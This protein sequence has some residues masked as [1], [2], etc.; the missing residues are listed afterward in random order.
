VHLAG[1]ADL[2]PLGRGFAGRI[3]FE[4]HGLILDVADDDTELHTPFPSDH[5]GSLAGVPLIVEQ[6]VIGVLLVSSPKPGLFGA[7]DLALLERVGERAALAIGHAQLR[8]RERAVAEALQHS[9]LPDRLPELPEVRIAARYLS[10]AAG[11]DVGGDFYDAVRLD[12]G[13]LSLTIGDVAGKGLQ[14]ASI[15]G[16][17]R[18]AVRAYAVENDG[19]ETV[20]TLV[21]RL[22]Y[23]EE[24]MATAQNLVLEPATGVLRYANAGHP[25]G[26]RISAQGECT[27]LD[28]AL[29]PPLG[30]S[31]D[32]RSSAT[33]Q[34]EAG[35]RLLLFTDG[36][37][38]R[39][40]ELLDTGLEQVC[41]VAGEGTQEDLA[42]LS[43]A[44]LAA[45]S[46]DEGF[47]DDVALLA[48]EWVGA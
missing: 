11:V 36:L 1:A 25:P 48:V 14:A 21:D 41:K 23:G 42:T 3:A 32:K 15:M 37:V 44:V 17:L 38:E 26:L 40:D 22:A 43:D 35:D 9:L 19:P 34:L 30:T 20:L 24:A 45:M 18:S 16:R 10:R 7:E 29:A 4:G 6:R 31:W 28:G 27:W 12:D 5:G 13:R 2:L 33:T 8:D 47:E 39:R 46:T